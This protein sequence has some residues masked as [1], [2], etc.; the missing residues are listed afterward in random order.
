MQALNMVKRMSKILG[1]IFLGL[2]ILFILL[3][4]VIHVPPVQTQITRQVESYLSAEIEAEVAIQRI[5]F[6]LLGFVNIHDLVVR[7]P[8]NNRILSAREIGVRASVL[9]LL[10]GNLIIDELRLSGF[11]GE[12]VQSENGLNIQFI[13]DAFSPVERQDTVPSAPVKLQFHSIH[14][15]DMRFVFSSAVNGTS[16]AV[17]LGTFTV[18]E[19]VFSTHPTTIQ[20]EKLFLQN[21]VMDILSSHHPDTI[22]N[23][24]TAKQHHL[25]LPD[26][27]SGIS[28]AIGQLEF[29]NN[30]FSFHR[31]QVE[32]AQK[33]DPNH[34][35]LKNIQI[36]VS[37]IIMRDDRLD[38]KLHT[39]SA[40]LPRFTLAHGQAD[41]RVNKQALVFSNLQLTSGTNELRAD[42]TLPNDWRTANKAGEFRA[43]IRLKINPR[44]L[45]YFLTDSIV[46]QLRHLGP[47]EFTAEAFYALGEGEIKTVSLK[48]SNSELH[49]SGKVSDMFDP[50]AIAWSDVAV[51]ATMGSDFRQIVAPFLQSLIIPPT[52]NFQLKSSGKRREMV[53]DARLISAWGIVVVNGRMKEV[54]DIR[55]FDGTMTGERVDLGKWLANSS[56]GSVDITAKANGSIGDALTVTTSGMISKIEILDQQINQIIFQ[57]SVLKDSAVVAVSV[58]D[59]N[60]KSELNSYISFAEPLAL[61]SHIQFDKFMLGKLLDADSALTISGD[62]RSRILLGDN[63]ME[64]FLI[65]KKMFF[66]KQSFEYV[67][68]SM[69]LHALLSPVKSEFTYRT[70]YATI[71][72]ES[73]FDLR[74]V[75]DLIRNQ[76]DALLSKADATQSSGT[77]TARFN[78]KL[79]DAS[80]V[81]LF[82]IDVDDFD[83]LQASGEFNEQQQQTML[84]ASTGKFSGYGVSLDTLYS[85]INVIRDSII[86][87]LSATNLYYESIK[88]GQL[89]FTILTNGDT[90]VSNLVVMGDT[91]TLLDLRTHIVRV[92][93]GQ[94]FYPDKLLA[95]DHDYFI[96]P[97]KPVYLG[98]D[99]LAFDH[100]TISRDSMEIKLNGDLNAFDASLR[101]MDLALLNFLVSTDT[102]VIT[103][104]LLSGE[105]S[106][107]RG[108]QINL[109]AAVDSLMLYNSSPMAITATA[110]SEGNDVPFEFRLTNTSNT[111]DLKGTY[112]SA[113]NEV[114]ASLMLDLNNP[115]LVMFLMSGVAGEM[116]GS[117]HGEATIRGSLQ[118]PAIKGFIGFRDLGLTLANPQLTLN[119]ENDSIKLDNSSLLFNRFTLY[120]Q[121]HNP[122]SIDGS[123][124]YPDY[125]YMAYN[126]QIRSDQ[127]TL[128][129]NPDSTRGEVRGKLVIDSDIVMKGDAADKRIDARLTIKNAT[130]LTVVAANDDIDLLRA[131]GIVEFVDPALLMDSTA[132]MATTDFYDSLIATLPDFN[133]RATIV[134]EDNATLRVVIDEQSGDNL[135]IS[136]R[137]K[138]DMSY[139][140]TGNLQLNG[141]YT[142]TKGEY[143]LSFYDLVKKNFQFVPGSSVT[144]TGNPKNGDLNIQAIHSVASNSIGLIGHEIGENEK[145]I[146]KRSL[147]Y[148]VGINIRGTI[149]QPDI[150]FSLDLPQNEKNNFP[151]LANKL[152]RLR[153]P[154]HES[155]LNKQVF[156]LLVL[157]GFI[158]ESSS[159]D[160]NSSAIAT[161]AL[162]NSVNS[163]LAGQLNRFANQYIKG[164]NIDVGIQSYSDFSS[165]GGQTQTAMDFRVSKS[166][167][168]ERLSFEIGGDFNISQDQSGANTGA[169]NYRGD[170]AIIYDLTGK[171][172]KQLKLF[173]NETYDI[174]YQEIR[175]TGISLIFI[176]DFD[177]K[178]KIRR[179]EK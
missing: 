32:E 21:T 66:H 124:T 108:Q 4:A 162:A 94:L 127:F 5:S 81:K 169:K 128:F 179:A 69:N 34:I 29:D 167:M 111:I 11:D 61:S 132:L 48:T 174:V 140:R 76:T 109:R 123:I 39:L 166:M 118:Q 74:E 137:A 136:G 122:L 18:T 88:L 38:A 158:P 130:R 143:R 113:S 112:F 8:Q 125:E 95:F 53:A 116:H 160:I 46:H 145:S 62:T 37:D 106:Y 35:T 142:I 115:E 41:V 22:P 16:V 31:A 3:I 65:G 138:L 87:S 148:Q 82:G 104:G 107:T 84:Q 114:D 103:K 49:A 155:E 165:P 7:D 135:E 121:E 13:L 97:A 146:Y 67:L 177:S 30:D 163:L 126:L 102:T 36:S 17:N 149:E 154:E 43:D 157:G 19:G 73:N 100:F 99:Q 14:L 42:L 59:P 51:N 56:L 120:D 78:L 117:I 153:Q 101:N 170:I 1:K 75:G 79:E 131:E 172:D 20:A 58:T 159:S 60:Y 71:N 175:N 23:T 171:K 105:V 55:T 85:S 15:E 26:F 176:R 80:I 156:G 28:L 50:D 47:S 134:I 10:R 9:N 57:G 93:S 92:D 91:I 129:N 86:T 151:V 2:L 33:F 45:E 141:D 83:Y 168:N 44:E 147:D 52:V 144:W 27:G 12:L 72:L 40:Q 6:S 152:E 119:V 89:D 173:N 164:V 178:R 133:I 64:G 63:S 68:D 161:T 110:V 77:R 70:D 25:L 98:K 139:D 24:D 54:S 150:S 90:A 96:D